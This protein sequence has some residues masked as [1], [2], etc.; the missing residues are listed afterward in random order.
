MVESFKGQEKNF[1]GTTTFFFSHAHE[2]QSDKQTDAAK[3]SEK[4]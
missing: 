3:K 4:C 1:Q 2:D